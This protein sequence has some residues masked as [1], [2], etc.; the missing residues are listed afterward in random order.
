MHLLTQVLASSSTDLVV[1]GNTRISLN[2]RFITRRLSACN[3]DRA[4]YER[5]TSF[6][7]LPQPSPLLK[8]PSKHPAGQLACCTKSGAILRAAKNSQSGELSN[9]ESPPLHFCCNP[10][11]ILLAQSQRQS[12]TG[13]IANFAGAACPSL[14]YLK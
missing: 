14:P 6:S 11:A 3:I 5:P 2:E 10:A 12:F 7:P 9:I 1:G 8:H 4:G 13:E